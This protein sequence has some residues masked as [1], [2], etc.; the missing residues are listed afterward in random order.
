MKVGNT[1]PER[2]G[3]VPRKILHFD[4]DAFFCAVEEGRDP[5]LRGKP[6]AVGGSPDG[7]GVVASCSYA[8]RKYGVRSAMPMAR[9]VVAFTGPPLVNV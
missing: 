1:I 4:L 6:F 2:Q 5:T 7:R 9:V 8:A 3:P